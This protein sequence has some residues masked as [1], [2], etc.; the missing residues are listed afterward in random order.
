MYKY[1]FLDLD[2][3]ITESAPG[4]LSSAR[5][6]LGKLGIP[7][8]DAE[9]ERAFI[10]PPLTVGFRE[11]YGLEGETLALA[12]RYDR[13]YYIA[14]AYKDAPLYAGIEETLQ[15]LHDDGKLLFIVTSK[16]KYIAEKVAAHFRLE[17]FLSGVIGPDGEKNQ[18]GKEE[19]IE[20]AATQVIGL[21]EEKGMAESLTLQDVYREAVMIGDRRYDME[22]AKK[23]GLL[24]IGALYGYGSRE[25]LLE[26]GADHIAERPEDIVIYVGSGRNSGFL[27]LN[28]V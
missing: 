27:C 9:K 6:A 15:A 17:R 1:V 22:A 3:T 18:S 7:S 14:G 26:A 25:E 11:L 8:G 13:E 21:L 16:P 20:E 5:Y 2:G 12:I 23:L 28:S 19:L 4:I 10:G 24:A